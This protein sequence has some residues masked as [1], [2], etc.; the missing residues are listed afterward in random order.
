ML[1]KDES[2]AFLCLFIIWRRQVFSGDF[3]KQGG[4]ADGGWQSDTC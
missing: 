2:K 3:K 1:H 4:K